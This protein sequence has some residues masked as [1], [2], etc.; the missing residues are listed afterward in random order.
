M[1]RDHL[2]KAERIGF[3]ATRISGTDGV[4]LE[5]GKWPAVLERMVIKQKLHAALNQ[6]K[7]DIVIAENCVTIPMNISLTA[8]SATVQGCE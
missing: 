8:R 2:D 7:L 4:S 5:I 1:E 3:V 6:F